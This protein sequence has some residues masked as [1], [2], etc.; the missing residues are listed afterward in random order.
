MRFQGTLVD[1]KDD[2]GFGF[3]EPEE[4]GERIFCH[5]KAFE[6]RVRRPIA[7][8]KVTCEV[9]K[10]AQGRSTAVKV[11]PIGL[12][13]AQYQA[14]TG[15][16]RNPKV[17]QG[18]ASAATPKSWAAKGISICVIAIIVFAG[19]NYFQR[20]QTAQVPIDGRE[21][22]LAALMSE[23]EPESQEVTTSFQCDGRVYCSEMHSRAEAEFFI[24]NCPGTKMDGDN[25][26]EP[27]ERDSRF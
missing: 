2:R 26:G 11:R 16:R 3:I 10:D 4:G 24:K 22:D 21:P 17:V 27:C 6:V 5:V 13:D 18:T 8:D 23:S 15:S 9:G 25:D 12:E 1:W 19:W 7:G 14:N 20:K